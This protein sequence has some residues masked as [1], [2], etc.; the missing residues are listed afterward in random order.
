MSASSSSPAVRSVFDSSVP[1]KPYSS[2]EP[3]TLS[4]KGLL[5]H[6]SGYETP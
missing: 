1:T 5:V 3:Y 6:I 4:A 2:D